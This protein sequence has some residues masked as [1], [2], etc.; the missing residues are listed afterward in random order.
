VYRAR[1]KR[2]L[3]REGVVETVSDSA[4]SKIARSRAPSRSR[5]LG[6]PIS[7]SALAA[8][9]SGN[10]NAHSLDGKPACGCRRPKREPD[11]AELEIGVPRSVLARVSSSF[12]HL[13]WPA[14][15]PGSFAAAAQR[16]MACTKSPSYVLDFRKG[17]ARLMADL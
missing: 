16:T 17:S 15:P 4:W 7:R 8:R 6:T 10:C 13:R 2:S 14:C 3:D 5:R 9:V 1:P 11:G 12:H